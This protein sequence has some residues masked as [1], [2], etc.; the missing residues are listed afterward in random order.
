VTCQGT[1][2]AAAVAF[3]AAD[4]FEDAIRNAVSLGGDAD[5][6]ACI[7]GALAEAFYGG[8]PALIQREVTS[9]LDIPLRNEVRS[10]AHRHSVPFDDLY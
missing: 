4:D 2:P 6:L 9:R 3:L 8:V 1:V 5:T 10:F 7:A